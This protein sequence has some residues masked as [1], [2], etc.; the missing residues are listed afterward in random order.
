MDSSLASEVEEAFKQCFKEHAQ[1]LGTTDSSCELAV[2][3]A[4]EHGVP[5]VFSVAA[6]VDPRSHNTDDAWVVLQWTVTEVQPEV[7]DRVAPAVL[8]AAADSGFSYRLRA[9]AG[10]EYLVCDA[11]VPRASATRALLAQVAGAQ[12]FAAL[13]GLSLVEKVADV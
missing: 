10:T 5:A 9:A 11:R 1:P 3:L 8:R 12:S 6:Y 2:T 13:K 4:D 7:A